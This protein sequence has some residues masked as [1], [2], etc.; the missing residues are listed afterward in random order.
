M[1]ET[2]VQSLGRGDPLEKDLSSSW[3]GKLLDWHSVLV[4]VCV[5]V[6]MDIHVLTHASFLQK[7][8][9]LRYNLRKVKI[10]F[11]ILEFLKFEEK[12]VSHA[13]SVTI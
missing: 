8:G 5:R 6:P 7:S 3:E 13:T 10:T 11:K 2:R 1:W 12:H 9:L 4:C